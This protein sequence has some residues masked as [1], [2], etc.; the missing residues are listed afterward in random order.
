M[1]NG[2]AFNPFPAPAGALWSSN[3]PSG[4]GVWV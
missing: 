1:A 3:G 4:F 2:K